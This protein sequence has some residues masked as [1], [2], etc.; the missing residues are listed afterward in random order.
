MDSIILYTQLYFK[1]FKH[2]LEKGRGK[3]E[4]LVIDIVCILPKIENVLSDECIFHLH[5]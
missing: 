1:Y 4:G 5:Y 2:I 3:R